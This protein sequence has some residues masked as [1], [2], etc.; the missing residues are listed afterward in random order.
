VLTT[1]PFESFA[2][3]ESANGLP[4]GCIRRL[5]STNPDT[6]AWACMER[7]EIDTD[8][9]ARRFKAEAAELG[10]TVD[11][12]ELLA[13]LGGEL[14]PSMVEAV[15]RCR[16]R[17]KV[18]LLTNNFAP[19]SADASTDAET[20]SR[21]TAVLELFHAKVE[22]STAGFRKPDRRFYQTACELLE[23]RPEE[24]VFLDDL[25]IN[26][27]PA[28]AMGM[29]TIKVVDPDVALA[30]LEEHVGFSVR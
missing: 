6:N 20:A 17:L 14:R 23:I 1:S 18:G 24:A 2:A 27:K 5:N 12:L 15:R 4:E 25:G 30:E 13:M 19:A 22:S 3:Y 10:Y 11:G 9:F 29:R 7:G 28:R 21:Y 16:E 26:L 8:E